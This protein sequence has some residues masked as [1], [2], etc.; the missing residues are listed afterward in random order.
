MHDKAPC[1]KA[2]HTPKLLQNSGI[3]FVPSSEFPGSSHDLIVYENLGSILKGL[4]KKRTA[5]YNGIPSL[6][7]M[8]HAV[9][10]VLRKIKFDS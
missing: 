3:V 4:L 1:V 2:L 6:N 10:K 5:N 9:T 8:R 7:D